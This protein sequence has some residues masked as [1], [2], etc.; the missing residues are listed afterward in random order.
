MKFPSVP[1]WDPSEHSALGE[2]KGE[3]GTISL[4][5]YLLLDRAA[6]TKVWN[7]F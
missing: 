5:P 3:K 4:L 6:K 2:Y 1:E 7:K